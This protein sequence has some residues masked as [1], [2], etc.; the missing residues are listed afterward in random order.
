M[1]VSSGEYFFIELSDGSNAVPMQT[2][3]ASF[4]DYRI[5]RNQMGRD[6]VG[7][8]L[9]PPG[10]RIRLVQTVGVSPPMSS[11]CSVFLCIGGSFRYLT[12]TLATRMLM[13]LRV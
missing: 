5:I 12:S 7:E 10:Q 6:R 4:P 11:L 13:K 2:C 9:M 3:R 1:G 8:K